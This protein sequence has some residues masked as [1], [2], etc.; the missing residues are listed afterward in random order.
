MIRS[1]IFQKIFLGS[2][3]LILLSMLSVVAVFYRA[4]DDRVYQEV[5]ILLQSKIES[6]AYFYQVKSPTKTSFIDHTFLKRLSKEG[7]IRITIIDQDGT[8]LYDSEKQAELLENHY[9]RPEIQQARQQE[10]G[11]AKRFSQTI[12]TDFLYMAKKITLSHHD[13]YVRAARTVEVINKE[14]KSVLWGLVLISFLIALIASIL[15]YLTIRQPFLHITQIIDAA[16]KLMDGQ[17]HVRVNTLRSAE[18][19]I[20]V[21]S[22]T[23][24]H[25]AS[26]LETKISSLQDSEKKLVGILTNLKDG[27]IVIDESDAMVFHNEV[28]LKYFG[29]S[30]IA[31]GGFLLEGIRNKEIQNMIMSARK[32]KE[33]AQRI[34]EIELSGRK[35]YLLMQCFLVALKS[36]TLTVISMSDITE[37]KRAEKMKHD[38]IANAS[39]QLKTPIAAIQGYAETLLDIQS[40]SDQKRSDYLKKIVQRCRGSSEMIMRLLTLATIEDKFT[41]DEKNEQIQV[42][43]F[44]E[45]IIEQHHTQLNKKNITIGLQVQSQDVTIESFPELLEIALSAIIENAIQYSPE[46]SEMVITIDAWGDQVE[47]SV[48][49]Q[50]IGIDEGEQK[51]IFER[52]Y[53]T[54]K[55][56]ATYAKAQV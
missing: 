19:E 42:V 44:V 43:E 23:M 10:W 11:S 46:H 48:K 6:I 13:V 47:I 29:S 49:D 33:L 25:L 21:L 18:N 34:V 51:H 55:A 3:A 32:S 52:F 12:G 39:H 4:L 31:A 2:T 56:Q 30:Y 1:K 17:Y 5:Q 45:Y 8:V 26:N 28:W 9:D 40:I 41:G 53:R 16:R 15:L 50:G 14:I 24:N 37:I 27:L 36:D 38:F 35:K 7:V 20:R 54:E 22:E